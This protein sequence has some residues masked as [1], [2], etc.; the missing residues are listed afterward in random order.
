MIKKKLKQQNEYINKNYEE[1]RIYHKYYC[2][3]KTNIK[4]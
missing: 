1:C 2:Q 3:E 4:K